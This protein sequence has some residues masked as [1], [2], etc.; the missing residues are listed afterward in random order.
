MMPKFRASTQYEDWIG[1][2]AADEH[3][4]G[5]LATRLKRDGIIRPDHVLVGLRLHISE[6]GRAHIK[7]IVVEVSNQ[8]NAADAIRHGAPLKGI[9]LQMTDVNFSKLFK[10]FE[11]S[12][13]ARG[14]DITDRDYTE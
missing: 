7:A 4:V 14:L 13:H 1:T 12:L 5:D 6:T 11:L 9:D 10:R 3:N 8:D 2:A